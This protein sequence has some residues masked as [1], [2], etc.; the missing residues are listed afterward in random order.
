M[1]PNIL[2][3]QEY[4]STEN[5]KT[6]THILSLHGMERIKHTRLGYTDYTLRDRVDGIDINLSA[7]PR[8]LEKIVS[9]ENLQF[10]AWEAL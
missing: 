10:I 9:F 7:S 2:F 1:K 5:F 3:H 4:Y 6:A 8:T